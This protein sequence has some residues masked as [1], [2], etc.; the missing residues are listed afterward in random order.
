MPPFS[1]TAKIVSVRYFGVFLGG[2]LCLFFEARGG[3]KGRKERINLEQL[4]ET[5]H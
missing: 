5:M 3:G 2:R 4:I 1:Q